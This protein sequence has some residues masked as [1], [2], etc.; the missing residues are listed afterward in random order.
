MRFLVSLGCTL[1]KNYQ[2]QGY[3]TEALNRIIAYAFIDLKKH[4][5]MASIDPANS[6]SIHLVERLGFRKEAHFVESLYIK[7]RW[8]DD[9]IY[10]LLYNDWEKLYRTKFF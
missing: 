1:S 7:G 4:R 10:A 8:V 2:N 3:A 5:I 6:P 9:L